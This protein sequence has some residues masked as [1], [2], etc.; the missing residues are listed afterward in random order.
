MPSTLHLDKIKSGCPG[1]TIFAA[2]SLYEACLVSLSRKGHSSGCQ[3]ELTGDAPDT[4]KVIWDEEVDAQMERTYADQQDATED[5]AVCVAV[6]LALKLTP[7]TVIER[8]AKGTGIDYWLGQPG[9]PLFQKKA[10]LEISGTFDGDEKEL[11]K[12]YGQKATQATR[13]SGTGLPAY[14]SVTAFRFP[15]SKFAQTP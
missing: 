11:E 2:G 15:K 7:F 14:V 1:L 8:S 3:L 4:L 13:S 12:R 10:R 5:G 6:L 9:D